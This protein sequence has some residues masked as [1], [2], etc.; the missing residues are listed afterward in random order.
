VFINTERCEKNWFNWLNNMS[1]YADSVGK[2]NFIVKFKYDDH[3]DNEKNKIV[4]Y[5]KI[6]LHLIKDGSDYKIDK[7]LSIENGREEIICK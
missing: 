4:L 7:V 3:Y 6:R 1:I 5:D 2:N